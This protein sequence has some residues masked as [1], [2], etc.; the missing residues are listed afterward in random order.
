MAYIF[1]V[2][3]ITFSLMSIRI[4]QVNIMKH[5]LKI[6]IADVDKIDAGSPDDEDL[7]IEVS[8]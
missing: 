8:Q 2:F 5:I 6:E 4:I 1:M 3:P 7:E